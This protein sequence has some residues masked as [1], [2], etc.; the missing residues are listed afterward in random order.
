MVIQLRRS[1]IFDE[2]VFIRIKSYL[3]ALGPDFIYVGKNAEDSLK[4]MFRLEKIAKDSYNKCI[5]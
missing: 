2:S 3:V 1:G 5:E 4:K